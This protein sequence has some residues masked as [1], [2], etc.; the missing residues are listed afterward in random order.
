MIFM[1]LY[2]WQPGEVHPACIATTFCGCGYIKDPEFEVLLTKP[3]GRQKIWCDIVDN[4]DLQIKAD[5]H[6]N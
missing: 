6:K 4:N 1:S 3:L 5:E 2:S